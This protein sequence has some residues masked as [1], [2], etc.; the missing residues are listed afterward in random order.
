MENV[1]THQHLLDIWNRETPVVAIRGP[2]YPLRVRLPE[3]VDAFQWMKRDRRNHPQWSATFSYWK[4]PRAWLSSLVGQAL[5]D[6]GRVYLIQTFKSSETCARVCQK[7]QGFDCDCSCNGEHHG[8]ENMRGWFE[9]SETFA[10]RGGDRRLGCR[11]L[12]KRTLSREQELMFAA[13]LV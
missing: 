6:F 11:L 1:H 10:T 3:N 12:T 2:G 13:I 4:A 8:E 5:A 9:V 7:A